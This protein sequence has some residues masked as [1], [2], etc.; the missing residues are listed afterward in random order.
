MPFVLFGR[1]SVPR[2]WDDRPGASEPEGRAG[3]RLARSHLAWPRALVF[4]QAVSSAIRSDA[5]TRIQAAPGGA[6]LSASTCHSRSA[7]S[8]SR[9][10]KP[11][12][13][14]TE[15]GPTHLDE[16]KET[17]APS[18]ESR[19]GAPRARAPGEALAGQRH[20]L[21]GPLLRALEADAERGRRQPFGQHPPDG[22]AQHGVGRDGQ[23]GKG[24]ARGAGKLVEWLATV[25]RNRHG[26][27]LVPPEAE[28]RVSLLARA[29]FD[30]R[31]ERRT[32]DKLA[33]RSCRG[34]RSTARSG[35]I[36]AGWR[37]GG[38]WTPPGSAHGAR[39]PA[40]TAREAMRPQSPPGPARRRRPARARRTGTRRH[41]PRRVAGPGAGPPAPAEATGWFERSI[42][43]GAGTPAF[44]R[45]PRTRRLRRRPGGAE[46]RS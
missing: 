30:G 23:E 24:P 12:R 1:T 21:H 39:A 37:S 10:G 14:G 18:G 20:L 19:S 27:H 5:R 33:L 15:G 35:G 17:R 26:R 38:S 13:H 22:S 8:G 42:S 31:L 36:P 2:G 7:T 16:P 25:I 41:A 6:C 9:G 43:W 3:R 34:P 44:S 4:R 40:R 28:G 45:D 32:D 11:C 46:E 29:A